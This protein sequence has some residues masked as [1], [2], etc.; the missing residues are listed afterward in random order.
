MPYSTCIPLSLHEWC[1]TNQGSFDIAKP[2]VNICP[3]LTAPS[4]L[5]AQPHAQI[6]LRVQEVMTRRL[7]L[8]KA[9]QRRHSASGIMVYTLV[10]GE[11]PAFRAVEEWS[12]AAALGP[13]EVMPVQVSQFLL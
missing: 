8:L 10:A 2:A 13:I 4:P 5:G 7:A 9:G 11:V 1:R 12:Q 3:G 6:V